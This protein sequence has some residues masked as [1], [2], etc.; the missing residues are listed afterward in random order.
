MIAEIIN[1]I[2]PTDFQKNYSKNEQ[3][4]VKNH[5]GVAKTSLSPPSMVLP[6]HVTVGG[7]GRRH[8]DQR[9][10]DHTKKDAHKTNNRKCINMTRSLSTHM[11]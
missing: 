4:R 7:P 5:Q 11:F 3:R 8:R 1:K 9:P 6:R 2:N 10:R